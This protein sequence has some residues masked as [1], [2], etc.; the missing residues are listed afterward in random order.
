MGSIAKAL[1]DAYGLW[2]PAT[3]SFK[4]RSWI[5]LAPHARANSASAGR[6][7]ISPIP[8]WRSV[9]AEKRGRRRASDV[10][11]AVGVAGPA[12]A[13]AARAEARE[14]PV[15]EPED[16]EPV[17]LV[18]RAV[19]EGE[20]VRDALAPEARERHVPRARRARVAGHVRAR[21]RRA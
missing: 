3:G 6:S 1:R 4:G 10:R 14:A 17:A 16:A 15:R 19:D 21:E 11:R 20:H 13:A 7:V 5:A 12:R 8:C 2:S 9:R 18:R